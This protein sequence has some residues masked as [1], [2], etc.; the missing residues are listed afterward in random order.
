[1]SVRIL[2]MQYTA[3]R[4][5]P[6]AASSYMGRVECLTQVHLRYLADETAPTFG[7]EQTFAAM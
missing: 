5:M 3:I 6:K 1:M 7:Q 2:A 4:W